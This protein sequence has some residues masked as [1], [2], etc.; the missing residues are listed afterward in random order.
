MALNN[1]YKSK[2]LFEKSILS[3][4]F[5]VYNQKAIDRVM[6]YLYLMKLFN[7]K[8]SELINLLNKDLNE[9]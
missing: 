1:F 6:V 4:D 5:I 9:D 2:G 7:E 8:N 3:K